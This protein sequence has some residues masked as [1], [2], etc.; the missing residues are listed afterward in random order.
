MASR[1]PDEADMPSNGSPEGAA[2]SAYDEQVADGPLARCRTSRAALD[3]TQRQ[4]ITLWPQTPPPTH[5]ISNHPSPDLHPSRNE[6]L[7]VS[8]DMPCGAAQ[9]R[10][11]IPHELSLQSHNPNPSI[12]QTHSLSQ[13]RKLFKQPWPRNRSADRQ[14]WYGVL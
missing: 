10:E 2:A 14:F 11:L 8:D 12:R 7:E 3:A 1:N 9:F 5:S 13:E 4:L 6:P